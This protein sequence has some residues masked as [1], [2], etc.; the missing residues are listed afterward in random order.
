MKIQLSSLIALALLGA[1][2]VQFVDAAVCPDECISGGRT[3]VKMC[4]DGKNR[5]VTRT[6]N[7]QRKILRRGGKCGVCSSGSG[8]GGSGGVSN[9]GA[10]SKC[11]ESGQAETCFIGGKRGFQMCEEFTKREMCVKNWQT[12]RKQA[13]GYTCGRC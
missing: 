10:F 9:D 2:M 12:P 11:S 4:K 5:C 6:Q 7:Q 1:S 3:G 8:N 13:L